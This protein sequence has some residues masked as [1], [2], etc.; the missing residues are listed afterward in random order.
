M[1]LLSNQEAKV[2]KKFQMGK[3]TGTL[4]GELIEEDM[5]PAY[6]SRVMNRAR[7]KKNALLRNAKI[8]LSDIKPGR[9]LMAMRGR[10]K[11]I[12]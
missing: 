10:D 4:S 6:V 3:S 5:S 2:W 9:L 11:W 8:R 12:K 7:K 1:G